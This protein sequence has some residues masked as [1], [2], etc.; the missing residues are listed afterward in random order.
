[1]TSENSS[2]EILIKRILNNISNKTSDHISVR[3]K[4]KVSNFKKSVS[5]KKS[6]IY[7]RD[8]KYD[9][10]INDRESITDNIKKKILDKKS[11]IK[12]DSISKNKNEKEKIIKPLTQCASI[13]HRD[14]PQYQCLFMATENSK[15]CALHNIEFKPIDYCQIPEEIPKQFL[16]IDPHK[17]S[18]NKI[19]KK[20]TITNNKLVK[21][22]GK[23]KKEKKSKILLDEKKSTVDNVHRDN[24]EDLEVKLLILINDYDNSGKLARLIGPVFHDMTISEDQQDPVTYDDIWIIDNGVK[25]P[26]N[27]NK[28]YLFSYIDTNYKIRCLTIFTIYNMMQI[29]NYNHPIT[30]EPIPKKD[31]RRAKR[32]IK[33]YSSKLGMFQEV[34]STIE[35]RLKNRLTKLF[36]QFH[37]HSIYFEESWLLSINNPKQLETICIETDRLISNNMKNINPELNNFSYFNSK[38]VKSIKKDPNNEYITNLQMFI[39]EGWEKLITATNNAQNQIPIWIIAS[40]LSFVV[41]DIKLKFPS[42]EIML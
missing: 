15:Y 23:N 33:F 16:D 30:L 5:A 40:G 21:K 3:N 42:L 17:K 13:R 25:K 1:M 20:I 29:K 38:N 27:I 14:Q 10:I 37:I 18:I 32:L 22:K 34:V 9:D 41:P 35:Y 36:K 11:S 31:I 26:A 12:C 19:I 24:E 4:K 2:F 6:S 28:Y 7:L 8:E 39:I